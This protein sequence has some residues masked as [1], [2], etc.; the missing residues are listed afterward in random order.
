MR[1]ACR[2]VNAILD[3]VVPKAPSQIRNITRF[4]KIANGSRSAKITLLTADA[5]LEILRKKNQLSKSQY[6]KISLGCDLTPQPQKTLSK[7]RIE[8]D[9]R[10]QEGERD[11]TIK[12]IG[13]RPQMVK[14]SKRAREKGN[15]P[16]RDFKLVK[17]ADSIIK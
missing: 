13:N 4:G 1:N 16:K 9:K 8:L 3:S 5:S 2:V 12:Y 14:S 11:I 10:I 7:L 15:S 6:P 17:Q